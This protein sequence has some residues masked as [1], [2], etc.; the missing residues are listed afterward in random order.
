MGWAAGVVAGAVCVCV[1]VGSRGVVGSLCQGAI[2]ECDFLSPR[3]PTTH[4]KL[5]QREGGLRGSGNGG[6][7]C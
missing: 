1:C 6:E 4:K 2:C 7:G 5:Q 3:W